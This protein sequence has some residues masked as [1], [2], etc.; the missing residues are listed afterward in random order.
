MM[1][2]TLK[3]RQ[4]LKPHVDEIIVFQEH[5]GDSFVRQHVVE[6]GHQRPVAMLLHHLL[7]A[8]DHEVEVFVGI[9]G[10]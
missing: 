5:K 3:H 9:W 6:V 7:R 10:T 8:V 4:E 2:F 1:R